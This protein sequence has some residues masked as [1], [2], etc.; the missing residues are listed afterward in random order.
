M[1]ALQNFVVFC[2]SSKWISHRYTYIAPFEPPSHLPPHPIP[3]GWYRAPVSLIQSLFLRFPLSTRHWSLT[4]NV[5]KGVRDGFSRDNAWVQT[6]TVQG[7]R[8]HERESI[9]GCSKMGREAHT[10]QGR[11][12]SKVK[13]WDWRRSWHPVPSL[14][15]KETGNNEN[16]NRLYSLGLQKKC[17]WWLQSWN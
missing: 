14:R 10:L 1:T 17:R 16:R 15:G 2:K 3:L 4:K 6:Y 8:G 5:E 11:Y 7:N 13:G 12:L 9:S